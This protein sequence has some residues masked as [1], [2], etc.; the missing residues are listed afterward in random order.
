LTF[1]NLTAI[2]RFAGSIVFDDFGPGVSLRSTPGFM[3]AAAPRAHL[4]YS[5][6]H[7]RSETPGTQHKKICKA[8]DAA[9]RDQTVLNDSRCSIIFGINHR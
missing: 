7:W 6:I 2:G 3:L 4:H 8:R 5:L 9:D 1:C